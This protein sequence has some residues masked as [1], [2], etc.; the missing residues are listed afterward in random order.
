MYQKVEE[1]QNKIA[2]AMTN[3]DL[4]LV[5]RIQR[6]LIDSFEARA[7]SVRKVVTNS[8]GKTPGID[9]VITDSPGQCYKMIAEI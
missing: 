6:S 7:M 5:Y 8:G 4:K 9:N 3:N 1:K 2:I